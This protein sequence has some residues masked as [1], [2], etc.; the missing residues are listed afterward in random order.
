MIASRGGKVKLSDGSVELEL[1]ATNCQLN[2]NA[3]FSPVRGQG[4][5]WFSVKSPN[6]GDIQITFMQGSIY[7]QEAAAGLCQ[8]WAKENQPL[9]F[10]Y[11]EMAINGWIVFIKN[12]PFTF[13]YDKPVN[14]CTIT[15]TSV[16]NWYY[17][18]L[19]SLPQ[20]S[21]IY[22]IFSGGIVT[23]GV[24]ALEDAN[25]VA[26][27]VES[28]EQFHGVHVQYLSNGNVSIKYSN[29]QTIN[30]VKPTYQLLQSLV[31]YSASHSALAKGGFTKDK[32]LQNALN[33]LEGKSGGGQARKR[34]QVK[35]EDLR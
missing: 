5:N 7:A 32:S 19:A 25:Q 21:D 3:D 17:A 22:S 28:H 29:G 9:Y 30:N 8:K 27:W 34:Y 33:Q 11:E 10:T 18:S 23:K 12:A 14:Y 2:M 4:S 13:Q 35:W 26:E 20:E 16:T 6:M 1:I 24:T 15:L 31:Q